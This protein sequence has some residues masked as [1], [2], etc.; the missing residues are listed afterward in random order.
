MMR[1]LIRKINLRSQIIDMDESS[2]NMTPEYS[3]IRIR[4]ELRAEHVKRAHRMTPALTLYFDEKYDL[5]TTSVP[6]RFRRVGLLQCLRI[7]SMTDANVLEVPEP[8]WLRFA[9]KNIL[10]LTV[11]RIS[12]LV[13]HRQRVSVTYAIENNDLTNLLWPSGKSHTLMENLA[14]IGAGALIRLSLNR[15]AFGSTASRDLYQSLSGVNRIPHAL[16]EELPGRPAA[17][18]SVGDRTQSHARAIFIGVLDDRKGVLDLMNAW[19]E[20]ERTVPQ[21][22]LTVVGDGKHAEAVS[23]WCGQRPGSRIFEGFVQ[24]H[25]VA[26]LLAE[27]DVVV[28]PSR[29]HGRWREQIGLPIIEGLSAGLTVVTTDETGLAHWLRDKGH[30]VIPESS[31]ERDLAA[32]LAR[33]LRSPLRREDVFAALPKIPGRIAADAWLHASVPMSREDDRDE[34]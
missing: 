1:G 8:L 10:L 20:V 31:V 27:S 7:L 28:A 13:R 15:I 23:R 2:I 24:H 18:I 25:D 16:I 6:S 11:W 17:A 32:E 12:G 29:R 14:R 26:R 4:P 21:A 5:G 9:A 33:A 22:T 19:P 30:V 3:S 34:I